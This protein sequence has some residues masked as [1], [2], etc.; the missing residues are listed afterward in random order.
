MFPGEI[1]GRSRPELLG[2]RRFP[3]GAASQER[4]TLVLL[5]KST[6]FTTVSPNI[7]Q[8]E[9]FVVA[10]SPEPTL[11]T[12]TPQTQSATRLNRLSAGATKHSAELQDLLLPNVTG[13]GSRTQGG[14]STDLTVATDDRP[15][16]TAGSK[17]SP[18]RRPVPGDG[19]GPKLQALWPFLFLCGNN[20]L[21]GAANTSE[22]I[23][24]IHAYG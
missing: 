1:P 18:A 23:P 11:M 5:P 22:F 15:E 8:S 10:F 3:L 4:P 7:K 13:P 9:R 12:P 6:L 19:G 17:L 24:T 21:Q 16:T 14:A 2:R 20:S